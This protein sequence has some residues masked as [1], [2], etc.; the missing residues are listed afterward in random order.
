MIL[1]IFG[2]LSCGG[3]SG[4]L[5]SGKVQGL[6][7]TLVLQNNN[8]DDLTIEK[9]GAFQ[10][11]VSDQ[12]EF[13]VSKVSE[14]CSQRCEIKNGTGKING[15]NFEDVEVVCLAKKWTDVTKFF[16][17]TNYQITE[18]VI[19]DVAMDKFGNIMVAWRTTDDLEGNLS[20]S[21]LY[22]SEFRD[23][24]WY[25][26]KPDDYLSL[27]DR[28]SGAKVILNDNH[29]A[30]LVWRE[31]VDNDNTPLYKAEYSAGVW[32]KPKNLDDHINFVEMKNGLYDVAMDNLGNVTIV[33]TVSDGESKGLY[34]SERRNGKW[35][36]P[37]QT[38]QKFNVD[39]VPNSGAKVQMNNKNLILVLWSESVNN[40][41]NS[42]ISEY[43]DGTWKDPKSSADRINRFA[44]DVVFEDSKM[45]NSGDI[46]ITWA[47]IIED[48]TD[49]RV[50]ISE[51]IENVW[52]HPESNSDFINPEGDW[53]YKASV[54]LSD[55][56]DALV[57][58]NEAAVSWQTTDRAVYKSERRKGR[59]DWPI[60]KKNAIYTGDSIYYAGSDID[61]NGNAII[62]WAQYRSDINRHDF[63]IKDY[64][65]GHWKDVEIRGGESSS[66]ASLGENSISKIKEC[67]KIAIWHAT[68]E[69][70]YVKRY[71]VQIYR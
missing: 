7:G 35:V 62:N 48:L 70:F 45:N 54:N 31:F 58:W 13:S 33:W 15:K 65:L 27:S 8:Q 30:V 10:F 37:S 29:H 52:K 18:P 68:I 44:T 38:A 21:K 32:T 63:F 25:H 20:S 4:Y 51:R 9:D 5:V 64:Q 46:I 39:A 24:E 14:P 2:F 43:I 61:S 6:D 55:N 26:P 19:S 1:S 34:R 47:R 57:V 71:Y 22:I 53:A 16:D 17:G 40:V 42:Y 28:V 69:Q 36:N 59:W 67:R 60:L 12:S 66:W 41:F 50:F 23:G 49:S 56:G 11:K 3:S